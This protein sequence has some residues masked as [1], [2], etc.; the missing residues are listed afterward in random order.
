M[1]GRT[2]GINLST[3]ASLALAPYEP[4]NCGIVTAGLTNK[5]TLRWESPA[6]GVKPAG[7]YILM[8][9]TYQPLWERKI[10]VTGNE[11]TLPYSKDNY[12]F[13]IQAVDASEVMRALLCFRV[14]QGGS[15]EIL[16]EVLLSC[17]RNKLLNIAFVC[18][19]DRF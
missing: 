9:E 19:I 2:P 6:K 1:S 8:R 13:G 15:E 16:M 18:Q 10:F 11:A 4:V 17:K 3:I 5:T 14:R 7:Y 12:F